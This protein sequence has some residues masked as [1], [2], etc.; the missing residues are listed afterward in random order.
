MISKTKSWMAVA[1]L[2]SIFF[3]GCSRLPFLK[4]AEQPPYPAI[5]YDPVMSNVENPSMY[6]KGEERLIA[7]ADGRLIRGLHEGKG[8]RIDVLDQKRNPLRSFRF[9]TGP[10]M[11][12]SIYPIG[13][14]VLVV[15]GVNAGPSGVG[16]LLDP[17]TGESHE[18]RIPYPPD[19][20]MYPMSLYSLSLVMIGPDRYAL[21][22]T[23]NPCLLV[24]RIKE[25]HAEISTVPMREI[26]VDAQFG[27]L[28]EDGELFYRYREVYEEGSWEEMR[29][30]DPAQPRFHSP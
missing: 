24:I 19:D 12:H 25:G 17:A 15:S 11:N 30:P 22:G 10:D 26:P 29:A 21:A 23:G 6:T 13:P 9:Q 20:E 5:I 14:L 8:I 27:A 1:S 2:L 28:A 18:L 4:P 3:V 7:L 16:T